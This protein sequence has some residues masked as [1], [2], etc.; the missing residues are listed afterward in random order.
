MSTQIQNMQNI[1]TMDWID[2]EEMDNN[3]YNVFLQ[4][5]FNTF[6]SAPSAPTPPPTPSSS[7]SSR[8][9]WSTVVKGG[10]IVKD[11]DLDYIADIADLVLT[12]KRC[13]CDF[14]F[15]SKQI[16]AYKQKGY[17]NPKFCS[18]CKVLKNL[19]KIITCNICRK[20]FSF[21][22]QQ[23]ENFKEKCYAEPKC[24]REC[25]KVKNNKKI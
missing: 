6:P 15:T 21:T 16:I 3:L 20:N 23:Q 7:P 11:T 12:C 8:D 1:F 17:D 10:K 25:K 24:C 13:S 5:F 22:Q 18:S 2:L 9:V 4:R 14:C 19:D